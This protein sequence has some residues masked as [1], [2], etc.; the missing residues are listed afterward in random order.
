MDSNIALPWKK[1]E[2]PQLLNLKLQ[3]IVFW[4]A[5]NKREC[6][7][8]LE[9]LQKENHKSYCSTQQER[10]HDTEYSRHDRFNTH[11]ASLKALKMHWDAKPQCISSYG[12]AFTV[13]TPGNFTKTHFS[14]RK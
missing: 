11:F 3:R 5:L 2:K 6:Q 14:T 7:N 13:K 4:H 1:T 12:A 9:Y 10:S 8:M